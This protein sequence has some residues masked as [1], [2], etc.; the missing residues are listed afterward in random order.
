MSDFYKREVARY[1]LLL[2]VTPGRMR[3]CE[4]F[5]F[6]ILPITR[7]CRQIHSSFLKF[8]LSWIQFFLSEKTPQRPELLF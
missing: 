7:R 5:V 8:H 2:P 1:L 3:D 6:V 4:T